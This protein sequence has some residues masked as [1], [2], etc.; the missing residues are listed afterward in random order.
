MNILHLN[1]SYSSLPLSELELGPFAVVPCI[2]LSHTLLEFIDVTVHLLKLR[3]EDRNLIM[4]SPLLRAANV[5]QHIISSLE[6]SVIPTLHGL[7]FLVL[8]YYLRWDTTS[9]PISLVI[10]S[11]S[12]GAEVSSLHDLRSTH[13]NSDFCLPSSY[14][15]S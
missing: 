13:W 6:Q 14:I 4:F 11:R 12:L 9:S 10:N 8:V 15:T 3:L 5:I 1:A 2:Q 7:P